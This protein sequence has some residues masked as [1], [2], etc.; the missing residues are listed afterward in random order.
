LNARAHGRILVI[1]YPDGPKQPLVWFQTE[2]RIGLCI[3]SGDEGMAPELRQIISWYLFKF[4]IDI[5]VIDPELSRLDFEA[6]QTGR[7]GLH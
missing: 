2:D 6:K 7:S 4:F 5:A 3:A 1:N